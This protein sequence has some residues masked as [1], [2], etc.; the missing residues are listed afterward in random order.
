M[1]L[2]ENSECPKVAAVVAMGGQGDSWGGNGEIEW[3]VYYTKFWNRLKTT[4]IDW[5]L[6]LGSC[7]NHSAVSDSS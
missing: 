6:R 3:I 4:E 1:I 5:K 7:V 2:G